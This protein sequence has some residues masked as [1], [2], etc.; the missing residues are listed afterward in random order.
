LAENNRR[1]KKQISR[2]TGFKTAIPP[3][4]LRNRI[5]A[6]FIDRWRAHVGDDFYPALRLIIPDKDRD[7]GMYGMK[8][9]SIGKLLVRVMGLNKASEDAE[10]LVNWRLPGKYSSAAGDFGARC[11]EV[12]KKRPMLTG[13]GSLTVGEVNILLDQLSLASKEDEQMPLFAKF[14]NQM[15]AEELK[16]LI[17]IILRQMKVGASERTI[18]NL[19]HPSAESLFNI[20]SSLKRV[21]WE[22][23]DPAVQLEDSELKIMDCFQPQLAAFK[24]HSF[25]KIVSRMDMTSDDKEFWIEEKLDG[26]RMQLHAQ[27][28]PDVPG[29]IE[30]RFWSRKAKDY[31]Y[32]YG[33]NMEDRNSALTQHL[34]HVFVPGVRSIVL[35]G[36][37]VTWNMLVDKIDVFGHLKTHAL[38]AQVHD[39]SDKRPMYRVFDCLYLNGKALT[40]FSLRDRRNALQQ[41]VREV[42]RRFEIHPYES[43]ST[44]TAIENAL[45]KAVLDGAEGLVVK[46]PR[47][48]YRLG[49]RNDDWI[50]VKPEYMAEFG[51]EFDVVVIGGFYGQGS[52]GGFMAS[53]LC[54]VPFGDADNPQKCLTF[55][56]VGGG[57]STEDY[58]LMQQLTAG[59]WHKF[60]G[61]MPPNDWIVQGGAAR[62]DERPHEWIR[63]EDSVVLAV[64][65]S[66]LLHNVPNYAAGYT[67]RFPRLREIRTD[68]G[69]AEALTMHGLQELA[70][71]ERKKEQERQFRLYDERRQRQRDV[72]ARRPLVLAGAQGGVGFAKQEGKA[73]LFAGLT[74]FVLS[75]SGAPEKKSKA[76]LEGMIK[77]NGGSIVQSYGGTGRIV[78]ISETR[79]LKSVSIQ[80]AGKLNIV[81]PLW[82][83]DC[84]YQS[85]VDDGLPVFL[86]PFQPK[87]VFAR[88]RHSLTFQSHVA[89]DPRRR[90]DD[91]RQ[92][93]R[94]WRQLLPGCK[95]RGTSKGVLSV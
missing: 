8:E 44:T 61:K 69:W 66:T 23:S 94:V 4:E 32:L 26:E 33:S 36:E 22:L 53:F 49:D 91:R 78:V 16:W 51:E 6:R 89:H 11:Y 71:G 28:N 24:M 13:P 77:A 25:D 18:L 90:G 31:T 43:A 63:P 75:G 79:N 5:I 72:K 17:R 84:I 38:E 55:C 39:Q 10:S 82:L 83:F 73:D 2:R 35:D 52:R 29:G 1:P 42:P 20:S 59:K 85:R 19:W 30:F 50:K 34:R 70:R 40:R 15:N 27:E 54:G 81:R 45:S 46:N 86:L 7:R 65:A 88:A 57:F 67:L 60:D 56:K 74:F 14:Y 68:K 41:S 87:W 12:I 80:K 64:K 58:K 92:R 3:H 21:C 9:K 48:R 76:E 62:P 37:M 93:R 47:S 95:R